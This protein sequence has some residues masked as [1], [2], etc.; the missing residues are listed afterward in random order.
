VE[1]LELAFQRVDAK[2]EKEF[3][4][5]R[6]RHFSEQ[7]DEG[8]EA[9]IFQSRETKVSHQKDRGQEKLLPRARKSG[10]LASDKTT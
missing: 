3:D 4:S 10:F 9:G 1:S 6:S 8:Q 5:M 2:G 7:G